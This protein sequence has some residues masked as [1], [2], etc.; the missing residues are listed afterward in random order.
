MPLGAREMAT[1][2][3]AKQSL[4]LGIN[5]LRVCI[6]RGLQRKDY[7]TYVFRSGRKF[8]RIVSPKAFRQVQA[9]S[10]NTCNKVN[11]L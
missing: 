2:H 3:T 9:S 4:T 10:V 8:E 5:S 1:D 7:G 6:H 11:S